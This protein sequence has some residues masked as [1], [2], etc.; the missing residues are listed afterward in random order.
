V[1]IFAGADVVILPDNDEPGKKH[2]AFVASKLRGAAKLV[3]IL[4]LPDLPPKGDVADW[5]A[6]GGTLVQLHE[7]TETSSGGKNE[8]GEDNSGRDGPLPLFPPL[9]DSEPYPV[10]A[11]SHLSN[12]AKAIANEVQVPL[13]LAA[14]S[15]LAA[16]SLATCSHADVMMPFGQAR[17]LSLFCITIAA[18]GDRKSTADNEA[19]W[20]VN[21]RESVL[22]EENIEAMR[23]W[24]IEHA[25]WAAEKRKIEGNSKIDF[26]ERKTF[27]SQLGN[28][29]ERPLEPNL[30]SDSPTVEGLTKNW[31]NSHAA[32]GIFSAEGSTFTAGH[33]MLEESQLKTAATLSAAWDGRPIKRIRAGDGVSVLPGRRL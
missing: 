17:P 3:R 23:E 1:P 5:I 21:K 24:R 20:P 31:P 2:A 7:L 29:P 25:A 10:D 33:G 4:E 13:A 27:L 12:A 18:S 8:P 14:Q 16:A 30:T 22:R 15:V 26:S 6:A 28:E 9:A 32:L 19:L 11:L